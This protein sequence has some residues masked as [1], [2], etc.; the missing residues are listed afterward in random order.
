MKMGAHIANITI[1][2]MLL[3]G[4][5]LDA[6]DVLSGTNNETH[7]YSDAVVA[8]GTN[9][10]A[11]G[12]NAFIGGGAY[13]TVNYLYSTI[14]GGSGNS[15][16]IA[17][18]S[19]IAGGRYNI[20]NKSGFSFIGGGYGNGID[21]HLSANTI[22]GG[23]GNGIRG[24]SYASLI[25]GGYGNAVIG[26]RYS[27]IAG[28]YGNQIQA[29]KSFVFGTKAWLYGSGSVLFTDNKDILRQRSEEKTFIG[30]FENGY[31]LFTD[32][33]GLKSVVLKHGD[34]SWN[35]RVGS[36]H[37]ENIEDING[38]EL[39]ETLSQVN[40][41]KWNYSLQDDTIKHIGPSAESFN[42]AF[43]LNNN[44]MELINSIDTDG[45]ALKAI[46][47]LYKKIQKLE[48]ENTKLKI[49][50]NVIESSMN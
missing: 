42:Q 30:I 19:T 43:N 33:E 15:V 26:S 49:R 37:I 2:S 25:S 12:E 4:I 9:N 41:Y 40:I 48:E 44:D 17:Q 13:N 36:S 1:A 45:V 39:L 18:Y 27:V 50:L 21:T 23:Y 5:S 7:N 38:S 22:S 20:I 46:Q 32:S 34:G 16:K 47:A 24:S 31:K 29:D 10:Y 8:G 14:C 35:M 3:S 28:G 11:I 6:G